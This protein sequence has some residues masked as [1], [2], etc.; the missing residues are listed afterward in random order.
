[1]NIKRIKASKTENCTIERRTH[2]YGVLDQKG[3]M[4]GGW[5]AIYIETW[6]EDESSNWLAT[7]DMLGTSY[8]VRVGSTRDGQPFG[9]SPTGTRHYSLEA[10]EAHA[11]SAVEKAC[12]RAQK[13]FG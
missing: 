3:R 12:K 11:A 5:S 8:I 13:K 9:A 2:E 4:V 7:P 6:V 1:M 10:A